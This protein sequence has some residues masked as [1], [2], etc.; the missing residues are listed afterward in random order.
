MCATPDPFAA[1]GGGT[2]DD[3]EWPPPGSTVP[4]GTTALFID[5][6]PGDPVGVGGSYSYTAAA[7]TFL[8][9]RNEA[10]GVSVV[11]KNGIRT[12]WSLD[13]SAPGKVPLS[14]GTYLSV[15]DYPA[16]P[17]GGLSV[18]GQS[19]GCGSV[20][21]RFIVREL[22]Y[23]IDGSVLRF[24]VDFEQHCQDA[25]PA[26]FGALRYR[27][28][29]SSTTPFGGS[30]PVYQLLVSPPAHGTISGAS[31]ACGG[32]QV[33]CQQG[34]A[35]P[36]T[37][38]LTAAADPGYIFMGWEGSCRG[39]STTTIRVNSVKSC[40]ARFEPLVP[41]GGRTMM[42]WES[43]AGHLVGR[44]QTHVL[45]PANSDWAVQSGA[46]RNTIEFKITG[47]DGVAVRTWRLGF[48]AAA[49]AALSPGTFTQFAQ[50]HASFPDDRFPSI[51]ITTDQGVSCEPTGRVVIHEVDVAG[52][53]TVRRFAA[54]LE[55]HCRDSDPALFVAIRF[56][57]TVTETR[58]FGGVFP[59]YELSV[60]PPS[61]GVVTGDGIS[62]GSGLAACG[63]T[64]G[65]P[66]SIA[67]TAVANPGFV[68]TGWAGDCRAGTGSTIVRV[69]SVK[70]CV[71]TFEPLVPATPRT[72]LVVD[73]EESEISPPQKLVF[74]PANSVWRVVPWF[75]GGVRI[76]VHHLQMNGTF[77]SWN[78][79]LQPPS[80]KALTAG[81][82]A[83]AGEVSALRAGMSVNLCSDATGRFI[84]HDVAFAADGSVLRFAADVEQHCS[85]AAAGLF[86]AI[87]Y[88]SAAAGTAPFGGAY[89]RYVLDVAPPVNGRIT[90]DDISC[91]GGQFSCSAS[92]GGPTRVTLTATPDA[93][94]LFAGWGGSCGGSQPT[95]NLHVNTVRQC[96]AAF[97]PRL[98]AA[99]RT[100]AT[101]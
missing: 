3:G 7:S 65:A 24:D 92:F 32:G 34:F 20:T 57:S 56:N 62:C 58:P 43:Q 48:R 26:L 37:A 21:G 52:D 63:V 13:F 59:R 2:C 46:G 16:S 99:V 72:F 19:R 98:A 60:Q 85:D 69:N 74:T 87:R 97:V 41:A 33:A 40:A 76:V 36:E 44:G 90:G 38:T 28:T 91:G 79:Q 29:S 67:M 8:I 4:D 10:N 93:G 45:S 50:F 51:A 53:G 30:Y 68:F 25:D 89:P 86:L 78:I 18:G 15:G 14:A 6:Q 61:R 22:V 81:T 101:F 27:S 42:L 23:G 55:H 47:T 70:A 49:G 83:P 54:D 5:S 96:S 12:E 35:A 94:Y 88:N 73:R 100:I 82:Y 1:A 17:F 84:V 39:T 9:G 75:G 64:F 11:V 95:L 77:D 66:T 80:G 31:I 71:A